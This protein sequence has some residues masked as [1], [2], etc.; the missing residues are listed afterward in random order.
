MGE[1]VVEGTII[2]WL[3]QEGDF[4]KEDE[5]LVEI[6]TD[7][8]DT[9]LPSPASGVLSKIV[10]APDET[11]EVGAEIAVIDESAG[12]G[13]TEEKK[14][15]KAE[16]PPKEEPESVPPK[17]PP[18]PVVEAAP[19]KKQEAPP[20]KAQPAEQ[21]SDG[22]ALSPLV[23]KLARERGVDLALVRGTGAGGRVTKDDVLAAADGGAKA[24]QRAAPVVA[25][26]S[27]PPVPV[28]QFTVPMAEHEDVPFTRIRKAIAE[29]MVRSLHTAAQLTNVIEVDMTRVSA[30]R[31][32]AKDAFQASEGFSLTFMPFI[33]SAVVEALRILPEFNAH[34]LDDGATARLYKQ[35]N[36]GIAVGRDEGLIVPVV[37]GADG[38]N[39]IGL[40]RAIHD[41]GSRARAKGGLKPDDITGGTFSITNYGSFGAIVDTPI[42]SMPQVA[43]LGVGAIVKRPAVL[44]IDGA[45]AVAIR[46]MMYLSLTYDHRWIDGHKAGQF[47]GRLRAILAEADYAH[48]LGIEP[49]L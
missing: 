26:P 36:M 46:Q 20:P 11:I 13:K 8:I 44:T 40:A 24:P 22:G 4:V 25:K 14:A 42:I 32:R 43:I 5:P 18:P 7:K 35:V 47:N 39:L 9:E 1:S 15:P 6:S 2:R 21:P 48:E 37:H 27:A 23:R 30:L 10:A 28:S 3:K 38:M 41:I 17:A 45:D 34:I 49:I 33:A 12:D 31:A 16:E 29:H 19:P